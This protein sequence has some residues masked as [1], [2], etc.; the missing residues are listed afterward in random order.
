MSYEGFTE[1]LC[2]RGHHV[3]CDCWDSDPSECQHCGAPI[4]WCHSVDETNG[5]DPQI[6]CTIPAPKRLIEQEDVWHKDHHGNIYA[7]QRPRYEPTSP[8]WCRVRPAQGIVTAI[9]DETADAG[10]VPKG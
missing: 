5:P 7:T 10:S 6:P 3:A 9:A 2:E 1:F 4:A 8:E